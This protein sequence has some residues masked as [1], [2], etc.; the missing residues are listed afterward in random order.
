MEWRLTD[1]TIVRSGG[2]VIGDSRIAGELRAD[3]E[4]P[5]VFVEVGPLPDGSVPLDVGNDYLLHA[6]VVGRAASAVPGMGF[7]FDTDYVPDLRDAPADV[8]ELVH[9]LEAEPLD[10]GVIY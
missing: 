2:V 8:Q 5:P 3:L 7:T 9:A 6:F 10:P 1:G 4:Q